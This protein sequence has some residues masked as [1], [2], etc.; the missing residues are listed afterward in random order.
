MIKSAKHYLV[1]LMFGL[2]AAFTATNLFA[3]HY[4]AGVLGGYGNTNWSR[5]A[6]S[7]PTLSTSLPI[8]ADD[9]GATWGLF[10]G[11]DFSQY[12]GVELR[13]QHFAD[14]KISF[15]QYNEYSSEAEG[16][17]AFT[18]TSTTTSYQLLS[19]IHVPVSQLVQAYSILGV[20][21]T[22][23]SDILRDTTGLAGIFGAG[24]QYQMSQHV[25]SSFEF[26]FAT[27]DATVD[28][29]PAQEYIPFLTSFIYKLSYYF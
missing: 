23:R 24:M 7:D 13:F 18:M 16:F 27:G 6:T 25:A 3:S 19:K 20:G 4:Y 10:V 8:S 9:D 29:K 17:P 14:S 21:A 11:D 2:V 22:H 5:I 1:T 12:F 15:A 26:D 28:L